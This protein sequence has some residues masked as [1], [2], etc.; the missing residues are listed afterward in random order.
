VV[1]VRV[2]ATES[3]DEPEFLT[4]VTSTLIAF[5]TLEPSAFRCR[6]LAAVLGRGS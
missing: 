4:P 6:R 3:D 1:V 5:V 2:V